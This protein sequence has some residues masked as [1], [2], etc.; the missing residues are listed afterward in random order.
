MGEEVTEG[1]RKSRNEEGHV[2]LLVNKSYYL[3]KARELRLAGQ[4]AR[5]G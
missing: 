1:W 5:M 4:V 3:M 2:F